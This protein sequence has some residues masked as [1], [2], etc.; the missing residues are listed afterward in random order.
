MTAIRTGNRRLPFFIAERND[1]WAP[2]LADKSNS[3]QKLQFNLF[4]A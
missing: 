2:E 4:L 1:D 3:A